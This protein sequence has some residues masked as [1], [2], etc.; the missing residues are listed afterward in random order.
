MQPA[1]IDAQKRELLK[2]LKEMRDK[3]LSG[4]E[5]VG[6]RFA[7]EARKIH[8]GESDPRGIFGKASLEVAEALIEEGIEVMPIPELP[9]DRN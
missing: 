9:D 5:D 8:Y 7:E 4:A 6:E 3:V 1:G 2:Q